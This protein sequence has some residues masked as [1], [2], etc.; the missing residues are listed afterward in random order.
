MLVRSQTGGEEN[1]L[2][3]GEM[4]EF[5]DVEE[6]IILKMQPKDGWKET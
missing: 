5:T 1:I 2:G 4:I 6:D 3:E